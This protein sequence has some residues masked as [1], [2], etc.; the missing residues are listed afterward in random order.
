MPKP[1]VT[2]TEIRIRVKEPNLFI[3]DTV[4]TI[5]ID[6]EKGIKAIVGKLRTDG[7]SGSM[8]IQA[9]R[10]D[11][12]K[13]TVE[14]AV[15]WVNEHKSYDIELEYVPA[16]D[17]LFD[18]EYMFKKFKETNSTGNI[19]SSFNDNIN[20]KKVDDEEN[21]YTFVVST[22]SI[23][24][25]GDI[26]RV[27]GWDLS[28]YKNNP[29]VLYGHAHSGDMGLPIGRATKVWKDTA[30]TPKRLLMEM[31]F[32]PKE[33]YS[34]AGLVRDLVDKG[35]IK[36]GSVRFIPQDFKEIDAKDMP[37]D[38][39]GPKGREYLKQEMVEYSI[40][41][42]PANTECMELEAKS[43]EITV[44]EN[45]SLEEWLKNSNTEIEKQGRVLSK[46]NED[47]L[48]QAVTMITEV[49]SKLESETETENEEPKSINELYVDLDTDSIE[50]DEIENI[51]K[52]E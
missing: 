51:F 4:R 12:E 44:T 36:T 37:I 28:K 5:N 9:Y 27:K 1:E 19:K 50:K 38:Y 22:E 8:K 30:S 18:G 42:I 20:I 45:K 49:L 10:F 23:D 31:E 7:P 6:T 26:L 25:D 29:V 40:V 13:W 16:I 46:S 14:R 21:K 33:I 3:D 39:N 2:D 35:F 52:E 15:A 48:R 17:G 47:K 34:F 24:R 43:K 41:T 11:K 32:V